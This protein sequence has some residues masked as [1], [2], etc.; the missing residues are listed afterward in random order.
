[1]RFTSSTNNITATRRRDWCKADGSSMSEPGPEQPRPAG[2]CRA[3]AATGGGTRQEAHCRSFRARILPDEFLENVGDHFCLPALAQRGGMQ[4]LYAAFHP[5]ISPA[6]D[7]GGVK[8]T[9]YNQLNSIVKPLSLWLHAHGVR[10]EMDTLVTDLD[11]VRGPGGKAVERI[12]CVS[13]GKPAKSQLS[14]GILSWL[15]T[16]R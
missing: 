3:D 14:R 15:L 2:H 12:H 8:R 7:S 9:P 10:F 6:G 1:M 13:V 5:G 4:T 11:F 16:V